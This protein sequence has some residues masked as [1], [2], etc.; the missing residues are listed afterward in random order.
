MK[1]YFKLYIIALLLLTVFCPAAESAVITEIGSAEQLAAFRDSVNAGDDYDG[2]NVRLTAD[3]DL[4]NAEWLPIGTASAPFR[5]KF[6][7]A[8]HK[9]SGLK[10]TGAQS[11]AVPVGTAEYSG[12][13][14]FLI[15]SGKHAQI[16][17]LT[18]EGTV[19]NRR[20]RSNLLSGGIVAYAGPDTVLFN[21]KN[22]AAVSVAGK[23]GNGFFGDE[24]YSIAGGVAA[25]LE[26]YIVNCVNYGEV[27]SSSTSAYSIAAGLAG[28]VKGYILSS[29]N[30][31]AVSVADIGLFQNIA[32]G[33]A[34][35]GEGGVLFDVKNEG[36]IYSSNVGG[37]I[38]GFAY[39]TSLQNAINSGKVGGT[40]QSGGLIISGGIVGKAY[41]G[42]SAVNC[43]NMGAVGG[44]GTPNYSY[45]GGLAGWSSAGPNSVE[46]I[47]YNCSNSGV[48][49]G[50]GLT[51]TRV[52][53]LVGE[54]GKSQLA[55]SANSGSVNTGKAFAGGLV[56]NKFSN[57]DIYDSVYPSG[58]DAVAYGTLSARDCSALSMEQL[59]GVVV[60]V[61]PSLSPSSVTLTK[62]ES[63]TLSVEL[64]TFPGTPVDKSAFYSIVSLG[65]EP[66]DFVS[67]TAD[68]GVVTVS[69]VDNGASLLAAQT[70]CYRS[71]LSGGVDR[72]SAKKAL[73]SALAV[74]KEASAAPDV[75]PLWPD[76]PPLVSPDISPV[77]PSGQ[78]TPSGSSSSGCDV[79]GWAVLSLITLPLAVYLYS[80]RKED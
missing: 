57:A 55:D 78:E 28:R 36:G 21:C 23:G 72:N 64:Q 8:G 65:A 58:Y 56:G 3:I 5:G 15:L 69:G 32:G 70:V 75:P 16:A 51:A 41:N 62:G 40:G 34:G 52:G 25:H 59:A 54:M 42:A 6:N 1:R 31:G 33:V 61:A 22:Y 46:N 68:G 45:A 35:A 12:T 9:I 80:A 27:K 47:F 44:T 53:G 26:G 14:L 76:I 13:A 63:K 19:E 37:G 39:G 24:D 74:V 71:A 4:Q 79:G 11:A 2:L 18:V 7:G 38:I 67:V 10:V 43:A 30:V 77:P 29:R 50:E 20:Q 66:A 49:S 73:I 60:T 17:N 48:I